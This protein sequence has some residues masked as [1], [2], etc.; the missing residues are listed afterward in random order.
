[1]KNF[2]LLFLICLSYSLSAQSYF[3]ELGQNSNGLSLQYAPN[4]I[5][6]QTILQY[7]ISKNGRLDISPSI[8][9]GGT[10]STFTVF[11]AGLATDY[12]ALKQSSSMPLSFSVGARYAYVRT[13]AFGSSTNA[14][15]GTAQARAY[16]RI[17]TENISIVPI[18]GYLHNFDL[19]DL[20][21]N[22]GA[23]EIA[24]AFGLELK[25]GNIASLTPAVQFPEGTTQFIIGLGY[26]FGRSSLNLEE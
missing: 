22:G 21:F 9:Y 24:A 15:I 18:L 5:V 11:S 13:R 1:M 14:H 7:I 19:E 4:Q 20:G 25:N 10:V 12:Y 2:I 26:N 8:S 6:D 23:L 16:H 3:S 17:L